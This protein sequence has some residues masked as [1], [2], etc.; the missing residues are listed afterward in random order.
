LCC[1]IDSG[2]STSLL[3]LA[4]LIIMFYIFLHYILHYRQDAL[5]VFFFYSRAD[6]W[7]FVS[8]RGV[9]LHQ[10]RWNLAGRSSPCQISPWSAQGCGFRAPKTL[11]IYQ[12]YCPYYWRVP[13]T[14]FTKFTGSMLVLILHNTAKFGCFISINDK[15][16]K[17]LTH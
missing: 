10:S 6:I 15:T 17:N 13:C 4:T 2:L 3:L 11:K 5:P 9:T 14:I 1:V 8:H 16:M 12:Y 7:V